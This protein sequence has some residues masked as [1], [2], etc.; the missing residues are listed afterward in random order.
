MRFK[1]IYR[2]LIIGIRIGFYEEGTY[3]LQ[4]NLNEF[5]I[6]REEHILTVLI[7]LYLHKQVFGTSLKIQGSRF[8]VQVQDKG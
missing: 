4:K 3:E 6:V 7:F 2:N 5:N 1:I 8:K